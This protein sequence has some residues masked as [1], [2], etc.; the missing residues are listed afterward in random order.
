[1]KLEQGCRAVYLPCPRRFYALFPIIIRRNTCFF[2]T[3][4]PLC[5]LMTILAQ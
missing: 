1:M 5:L 3:N 4:S 2:N